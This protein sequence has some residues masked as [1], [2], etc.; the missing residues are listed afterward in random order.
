VAAIA[1]VLLAMPILETTADPWA[2]L[3]GVVVGAAA[4][5]LLPQRS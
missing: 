2:G 3:T 4:G 1:A 5:A